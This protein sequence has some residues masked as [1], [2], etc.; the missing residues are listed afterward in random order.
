MANPTQDDIIL[1]RFEAMACTKCKATLDTRDIPP[2]TLFQCPQCGEQL[3]M[4]ARFANFILLEVFGKGGMGAVYR[5][6]DQTLGRSVAIKVTQ[7][8]IAKDRSFVAQ[9][10]QEARALAAIN[11][12]NIVQIYS[13]GEQDGQ[14]YIVM[15]LVDGDRLDRIQAKRKILD[16]EYVL[17]VARQVISGLDAANAAGMTHGDI[18]PA[19]I[20]FDRA[21]NAKVADFGLARFAGQKPKPGE[22][23]GTPFYVAPEV[24]R[25]NSPRAPA[26]IY[27]LGATLYHLMTG[28]PPFNGE[29]VTDT[30]LLRFKEPAP[31]PREFK[32]DISPHTAAL[33]LRMLEA[34]PS[35]RHPNYQS[36]LYDVDAALHDLRVAR[37]KIKEAAP[38][39]APAIAL[40]IF[41][42]LAG[43]LVLGGIGALVAHNIKVKNA[44]KAKQEQIEADLRAGR[45]RQVFSGGKM[46]Y[47]A[48]KP[49][50]PAAPAAT[51]APAAK[52]AAPDGLWKL[53]PAADT[54]VAGDD[55]SADFRDRAA[56]RLCGGSK[57]PLK[58]A[59]KIYLSFDLAG[60]DRAALKSA[61]LHL[62]FG[63]KTGTMRAKASE[64]TLQVWRLSAPDPWDESITWSTAPA[65]DP[66]SIDALDPAGAA[67]VTTDRL[68]SNPE[69]G[70]TFEIRDKKLLQAVK[71]APGDRLTLV[72]TAD[73]AADQRNGWNIIASEDERF[74]PLL[75]LS[76]K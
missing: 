19:N 43:L 26:D 31:D 71:T 12:P 22:I 58:K 2:F 34:D 35:R 16:E 33:L 75:I 67:L 70:D 14:P 69:F 3:R 51:P 72:L 48:V 63:K 13:Y 37:G 6:F 20:L 60:V 66:A 50:A 56:L 23:W 74:P 7:R 29:T 49:D 64:Y 54:F 30:V 1:E 55:Q 76:A 18:K 46:T 8:E 59:S 27:S 40:A 61:A 15:E 5:A 62:T 44:E 38:S 45:I 42:G 11:H 10:L 41:G 39:K 24:V 4:P 28:E 57:T 47:V 52:P 68:P 53:R 25:G 17:A 36:L 65:N 21:G 73:T 9:F 32:A